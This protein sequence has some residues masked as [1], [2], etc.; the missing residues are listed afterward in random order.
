MYF[1]I[2]F[3]VTFEI[4]ILTPEFG[5]EL[6]PRETSFIG[7]GYILIFEVFPRYCQ[8]FKEIDASLRKSEVKTIAWTKYFRANETRCFNSSRLKNN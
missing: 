1:S 4:K 8:K 7:I 3:W 6:T 2:N 5:V